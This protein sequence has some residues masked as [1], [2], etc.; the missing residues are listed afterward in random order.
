MEDSFIVGKKLHLTKSGGS[1]AGK[2]WTLKSGGGSSLGAL[3]KFTPMYTAGQATYGV[4]RQVRHLLV[5]YCHWLPERQQSSL[6]YYQR[7]VAT[8]SHVNPAQPHRWVRQLLYGQ[9]RHHPLDDSDCS[10]SHHWQASS[11]TVQSV[12]TC[13]H[14]RT[15]RDLLSSVP[16]RCCSL[17][18]VPTWLVKQLKDAL[19][20][21]ICPLCNW[22]LQN[23]N[24]AILHCF[25]DI[26]TSVVY[27]TACD[28]E[29]SFSFNKTVEITSHVL[30]SI[31]G[32]LARTG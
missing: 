22:S 20:P 31:E 19:A 28:R 14:Q 17:D 24:V 29:A 12:H 3:Q 26:N 15:H 1:E 18:P 2:P 9:N 8:S 27:V 16:S 23:G 11:R 10:T 32:F 21:V 30:F 5:N 7:T 6:V 4:S 13:H 25:R